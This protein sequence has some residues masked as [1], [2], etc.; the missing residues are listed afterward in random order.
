MDTSDEIGTS[1]KKT[2]TKTKMRNDNNILD[3]IGTSK[4]NILEKHTKMMNGKF[5]QKEQNFHKN[6]KTENRG[7]KGIS[8]KIEKRGTPK[9]SISGKIETRGRPRKD[10]Y[11]RI[12]QSHDL[13]K[14]GFKVCYA[15]EEFVRASQKSDI[16]DKKEMYDTI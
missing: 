10:T 16:L 5:S 3:K 7:R 13:I 12:M 1:K 4:K 2:E 14:K 9:I 15:L 11:K 8:G 6:N